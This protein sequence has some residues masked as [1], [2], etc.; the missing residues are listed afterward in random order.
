MLVLTRRQD[1]SI[2]IDGDIVVTILGVDGEKVKLG[3]KA[4]KEVKVFRQEL[5]QAILEQKN[6]KETLVE[7][8][9]QKKLE[10]LR[11]LL[12]DEFEELGDTSKSEEED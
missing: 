7:D 3:I 2:V 10:M 6:I 9:E 8:M 11:D 12:M 5:F 1:E 4:P